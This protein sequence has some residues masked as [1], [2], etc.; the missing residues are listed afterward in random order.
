MG[1]MTTPYKR[2]AG[3]SEFLLGGGVHRPRKEGFRVTDVISRRR[4]REAT[5]GGG[6]NK[7]KKKR[8]KSVMRTTTETERRRKKKRLC[9]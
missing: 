8:D 9:E 1:S 4:I 5:E 7:E 6:G 3:F 2:S